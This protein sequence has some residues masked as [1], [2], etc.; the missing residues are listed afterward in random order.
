MALIVAHNDRWWL[1]PTR[2]AVS[3]NEPAGAVPIR[4][5]LNLVGI[6]C[7]GFHRSQRWLAT[8]TRPEVSS[9]QPGLCSYEFKLIVLVV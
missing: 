6:L 7:G 9:E 5:V 8:A 1:I 4:I 2:P 3:S